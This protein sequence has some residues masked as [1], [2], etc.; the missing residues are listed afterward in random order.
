[1]ATFDIQQ[2]IDNYDSITKEFKTDLLE[3]FRGNR[4][5][6]TEYADTYQK[7]MAEAMREAF[8]TPLLA[9]QIEKL[10]KENEKLELE[11]SLIEC[12]IDKCRAQIDALEL[13]MI[14]K[15]AQSDKDLLVKAA[16]ISQTEANTELIKA[17]EA[18]VI[19]KTE[20][21]TDMAVKDLLI[22]DEQIDKLKAETSLTNANTANVESKTQI[23][24]F[25][26]TKDGLIKD[27]EA[28]LKDAQ[29]NMTISQ[30]AGFDDNVNQKLFDAQ[31]N[32]WSLMFSSGL[33][34]EKP[35][36]ITNDEVSALY[37]C[38]KKPC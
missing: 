8:Q 20:I 31:M 30:T 7:L 22:K 16:Q 24:E 19:N 3:E 13:D 15:Q 12:E 9:A 27:K 33:L 6:G 38:I 36:I 34:E 29:T 10:G 1:M 5:K 28:D 11:K 35:S 21:D 14:I 17:N 25:Q 32:A 18:N 26:S 4:I 2:V 37:T 23:Q